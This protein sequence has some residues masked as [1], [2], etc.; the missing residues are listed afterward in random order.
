[1][2][3]FRFA[4]G[5][6]ALFALASAHAAPAQQLTFVSSILGGEAGLPPVPLLGGVAVSPDSGQLY[7]T[8]PFWD[9]LLVYA[10]DPATGEPSF[11]QEQVDGEGGVDGL[12]GASDVAVSADGHHVYATGSTDDAVAVFARD[13]AT[14][15]LT[16]VELARNGVGGVAGLDEPSQL[17]VAPDDASVYVVTGGDAVAAFS[18]EPGTG[19]LTFLEAELDSALRAL[20]APRGPVATADGAFVYVPSVG[21]DGV[22]V[23]VRDEAGALTFV[24][25]IQNGDPGVTNA[26]ALDGPHSVA[27]PA[28]ERF[29]YVATNLA[30]TLSWFERDAL[31]G[32]LAFA[33][34]VTHDEPLDRLAF[35]PDGRHLFATTLYEDEI[36]VFPVDP[37]SGA[38]AAATEVVTEGVGGVVGINNL[39]DIAIAPD[40]RF[41][42]VS[43]GD[44][45]ATFELAPEPGAVARMGCA[46]AVLL[47]LHLTHTRIRP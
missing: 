33:G 10:C 6:A 11:L 35:A 31:T 36:A 29:L 24:A 19:A 3:R 18:R 25:D 37:A 1:M 44:G 20:R 17:V 9:R 23:F 28:D 34:A 43:S 4:P 46:L 16:F 8:S 15:A 5:L 27:L 39:T 26:S 22:A 7:V 42:Y 45:L 30:Q 40:G 2:R 47:L 14:G 38:A 32:L 12:A 13:A 41:A 21:D